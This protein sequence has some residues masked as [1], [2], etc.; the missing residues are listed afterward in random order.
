LSDINCCTIRLQRWL[1]VE[2]LSATVH[3]VAAHV[4]SHHL[5]AL[6]S[7]FLIIMLI[8]KSLPIIFYHPS[9]HT[10]PPHI[11]FHVLL[12]SPM[13]LHH[14][15]LYLSGVFAS[16]PAIWSCIAPSALSSGQDRHY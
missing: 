16:A 8:H 11:G 15:K 9:C 3:P 4:L 5:L 13:R 6:H 1:P 7:V 12:S 2:I 14:L 10:M